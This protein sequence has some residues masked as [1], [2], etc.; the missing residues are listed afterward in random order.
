MLIIDFKTRPQPLSLSFE[1]ISFL[2]TSLIALFYC[3]IL[4]AMSRGIKCSLRAFVSRRAVRLFLRAQA[5][6]KFVLRAA[7]TLENTN[8]EQREFCCA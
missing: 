2:K 7:S 8:G 6:I 1:G 5:V 4:F 3:R